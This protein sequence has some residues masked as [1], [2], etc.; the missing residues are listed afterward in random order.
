MI[1]KLR[2]AMRSDA[3]YLLRLEE[4]CMRAYAEA[5]WG[6]WKQTATAETID[7]S[8]HYII[9]VNGENVGCL[10]EMWNTDHLFID[11][12]FI[13]APFQR[14]GIG[15]AVMRLK[16][17]DTASRGLPIK[18]SV[19]TTNPADAFYRRECFHVEAE[20]SERR[21]MSNAESPAA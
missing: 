19:L 17:Q 16:R 21:F 4:T 11:E 10:A 6:S 5:L 13:D 12:L 15:A 14:R 18:L 8:N 2:R 1:V 20:T 3:A 9:E 7:I